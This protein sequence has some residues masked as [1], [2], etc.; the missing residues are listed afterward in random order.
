VPWVYEQVVRD[1]LSGVE[2]VLDVGTGGGERL[3]ELADSYMSAVGIDNDPDMIAVARENLRGPLSKKI[4]FRVASAEA[5]GLPDASVDVVLNRHSVVVV[6]EIVRVLNGRGKFIWQT[7]GERNLASVVGPFGGQAPGPDQHPETVR[8]SFARHGLVIKRLDEYDVPYTFLDLE[9]LLF[10][11]KAI[12]HYL[13][14]DPELQA[15]PEVL[16][17]VVESTRTT[18]GHY[19]S[20]EHRWLLIAEVP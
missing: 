20:S 7:L 1:H 16:V 12:I 17:N 4:E 10:Q 18:D 19:A 2:K 5:V 8:D 3:I 9:S 13:P 14:V 11:I 6:S 15:F